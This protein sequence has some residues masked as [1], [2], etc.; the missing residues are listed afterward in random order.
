MASA[1]Q[2]PVGASRQPQF[3][4]R[5]SSRRYPIALTAHYHMGKPG[6]GFAVA[7]VINISS[8]GV[9]I[10][11]DR[12]LAARQQIRLR[13]DWP[14]LLNKVVPL[15]L[16]IEGQIVRSEGTWAAVRILKSEFRTRPVSYTEPTVHHAC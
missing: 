11:S 1:R 3:A 7:L 10:Q 12:P 8:G 2:S 13:I 14:A 16:H 4:E 5:R 6:E 15:A 9:L